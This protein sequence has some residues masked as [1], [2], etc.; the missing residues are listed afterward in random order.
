MG[1]D[2]S[3]EN[4]NYFSYTVNYFGILATFLKALPDPGLAAT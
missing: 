4:R 1:L 2:V 3:R